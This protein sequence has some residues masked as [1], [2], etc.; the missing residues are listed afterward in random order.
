[1]MARP[2]KDTTTESVNDSVTVEVTNKPVTPNQ[3]E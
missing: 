1:M 2:K 3:L